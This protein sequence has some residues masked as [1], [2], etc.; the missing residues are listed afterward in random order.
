MA[1]NCSDGVVYASSKIN[2]KVEEHVKASKKPVLT[3]PG[4]ENYVDAYAEFYQSIL[5]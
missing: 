2:P 3:F 5:K 1:V 4:E